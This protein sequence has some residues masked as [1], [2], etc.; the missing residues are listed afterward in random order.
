MCPA[1]VNTGEQR[2]YIIPIGGGELVIIILREFS[3]AM[4]ISR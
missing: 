2:G 1:P 3:R 4:A